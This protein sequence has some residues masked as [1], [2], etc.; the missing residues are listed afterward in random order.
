MA[1]SMATASTRCLKLFPG[2]KTTRILV[3]V[4]EQLLGP[5]GSGSWHAELRATCL[6]CGNQ[7]RHP[8]IPFLLLLLAERQGLLGP[9]PES[10]CLLV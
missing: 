6:P 1:L 8:A 10:C 7:S 4:S 5:V 9:D 3:L 2:V